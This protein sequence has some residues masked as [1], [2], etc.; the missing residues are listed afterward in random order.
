[1]I[2]SADMTLDQNQ[3]VR[4]RRMR[5]YWIPPDQV[6]KMEIGRTTITYIEANEHDVVPK[7]AFVVDHFFHIDKDAFQVLVASPEF[8]PV[9][10]DK[11]IPFMP[12]R[13]VRLEIP[14]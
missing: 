7:G 4:E 1:M 8:S 11:L 14:T 5:N 9:P 13:H 2:N 3:V 12:S 6:D 10:R